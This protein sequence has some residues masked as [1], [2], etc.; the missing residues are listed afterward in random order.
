MIPC[1]IRALYLAQLSERPSEL[2]KFSTINT[3]LS[4][5]NRFRQECIH[6]V[7]FNRTCRL[8]MNDD[9]DSNNDHNATDD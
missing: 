1:E 7:V 6:Q 5:T 3:Q 8:K 2:V 9:R 4:V